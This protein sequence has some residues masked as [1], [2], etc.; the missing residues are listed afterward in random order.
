MKK[1]LAMLVAVPAVFSI[2]TACGT[3]E[4]KSLSDLS[5]EISKI[6]E[7][8]YEP[9]ENIS[10]NSEIPEII[11]TEQTSQS[12]TVSSNDE[13]IEA[14]NRLRDAV[15]SSDEDEFI[16]NVLPSAVYE[17][18]KYA[19]ILT[20]FAKDVY[21]TIDNYNFDYDNI[22]II[23]VE[24]VDDK[25][26][27]SIKKLYIYEM[28]LLAEDIDDNKLEELNELFE[29]IENTVHFESFDIVTMNIN[30]EEAKVCFFKCTGEEMKTEFVFA[31]EIIEYMDRKSNEN[32]ASGIASSIYKATNSA[33][34]EL[35][36][37]G[38][39]VS[40][41]HI[42]CSDNSKNIVSG[43][44]ADNLDS[45]Y[46]KMSVFFNDIDEYDYF[47]VISNYGCY[48]SVAAC[49]DENVGSFPKDSLIEGINGERINLEFAKE[50]FADHLY[51][52][53]ELYKMTINSLY[54]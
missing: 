4:S 37:E 16:K 34:A 43:E 3:D 27:K 9:E 24:P 15:L 31:Q 54:E 38:I 5:S 20:E 14:F 11:T 50:E 30:G 47:V 35:D 1:I 8:L 23:S 40:G 42:I 22:E 36:E 41:L 28:L 45:L 32:S 52:F 19:G 21:L 6:L 33:L 53:D 26:F 46:K 44:L 25:W 2:F 39:D 12:E 10:E 17:S 7:N 18:M 29:N 48:Y 51:D 49:D 13:Y